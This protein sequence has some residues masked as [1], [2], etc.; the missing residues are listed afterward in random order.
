MCKKISLF[1]LVLALGAVLLITPAPAKAATMELM[2]LVDISGSISASEF[3]LQ[4]AG[5]ANAFTGTVTNLFSNP[6]IT[7]DPFYVSYGTWSGASQQ[8]QQ[9]GWTYI[10]DAASATAFGNAIAA[11][12]RPANYNLTAVQTAL[13]WGAGLITGNS[14]ASD[15]QIIDISG[16][17]SANDGLSGTLGR[18]AA[19]AAGI[20]SINGLAILGSEAGLLAY[21]QNFVVGGSPGFL[22][23]ATGFDTFAAAIDTKLTYEITGV[24]LPPSMLLLGS[25]LLGLVGFRRFRKS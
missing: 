11:T 12:T 2:L 8:Y 20:D 6:N 5:Y 18:D 1:G 23:S 14:I 13:Q 7:V 21:Y 25:G 19:L 16:D 4:K 9:V 22:L 3:D 15:R 17:G 24:P 10:S